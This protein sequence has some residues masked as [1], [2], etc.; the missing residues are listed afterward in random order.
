MTPEEPKPTPS[1]APPGLSARTR[2]PRSLRR[3][4]ARVPQRALELTSPQVL[5]REQETALLVA[6]DMGITLL[7][8]TLIAHVL[9]ASPAHNLTLDL[10]VVPVALPAMMAMLGGYRQVSWLRAHLLKSCGTLVL[11]VAVALWARTLVAQGGHHQPLGLAESLTTLAL[12]PVACLAGRWFM[13]LIR[14][15]NPERTLIVGGGVLASRVIELSRRRGRRM[16]RIEGYLDDG[17]IPLE[18]HASAPRLGDVEDLPSVLETGR[19]DRV[20]VAFTRRRD[21]ELMRVIRDCDTYGVDIDV[22]PRFFDYLGPDPRVHS[23]D[24]LAFLNVHGWRFGLPQRA[25]KRTFDILGAGFVLLCSL[26]VLAVAAVAIKLEDRGPVFY[27]QR[28]VGTNGEHFTILKL[29]TMSVNADRATVATAGSLKDRKLTIA[30]AVASLKATG[31]AS[32]TRVGGFLRRSSIDELPQL[33]NVLTGDMSLIG[34]RPLQDFEVAELDR[35]E[36]SRHNMRPGITGLW[37]VIGRSDLDWDERMQLDYT[38]VRHWSPV[39]DLRILVDTLPVTLRGS[40][41]N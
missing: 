19:I 20:V 8:C 2:T 33:W 17:E 12:V 9:F 37:Q 34:P 24:G 16:F 18:A 26:P 35:W 21:S 1:L 13:G 4:A 32:T 3:R 5:G 27:R 40:G 38:Y 7:V 39:L 41:A 29:R 23:V 11:A 6:W 30:D 10:L 22:I 36:L 28:R 25:F 14:Q 15:A 31:Q